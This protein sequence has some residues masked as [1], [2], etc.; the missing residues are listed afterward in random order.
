MKKINIRVARQVDVS[1]LVKFNQLMAWETE[2][3]KLDEVVLSKGV[4]ALITDDTK[5]FY[6]VA[7]YNNEV[8]GSL[9]VTT[10]WS[11]WRNGVFW[12]IQSVYIS[13][14][15]RRQGIYAQLYA[16]VKVLAEQQKNV[17]GFRLYVEKENFI[18]QKTYENLGMEET[19]YLMYEE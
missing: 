4:S 9:M 1:L 15:Y 10:E 11:D 6:L 17:C 13:P 16:Q 14:D 8:V 2:Q 3:K 12:W 5:G 19:H 7:E 18:A